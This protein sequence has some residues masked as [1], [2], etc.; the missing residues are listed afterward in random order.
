MFSAAEPQSSGNAFSQRLTKPRTKHN[1]SCL[2][3]AETS[4][5]NTT[6]INTTYDYAEDARV[7][8]SNDSPLSITGSASFR[9]SES[10]SRSATNS[11]HEAVRSR[12]ASNITMNTSKRHTI[13]ADNSDVDVAAAIALLQELK[14]RA[15]PED[16]IL[17][18]KAL[19]PTKNVERTIA[20]S[21][22]ETKDYEEPISPL[23]RRSSL[24]P[25]GVKTRL[26]REL[27]RN[28]SENN[29]TVRSASVSRQHAVVESPR[30]DVPLDFEALDLAEGS[31]ETQG[32]RPTTPSDFY[33]Q[34][35]TY[36]MGSLRITNGAASPEPARLLKRV[37]QAGIQQK[38]LVSE[39]LS[40]EGFIT[41]DEGEHKSEF[42]RPSRATVVSLRAPRRSSEE[43]DRK[44]S[45]DPRSKSK[46]RGPPVR[47]NVVAE[48]NSSA[49]QTGHP[50]NSQRA[51]EYAQEYVSEFD[52]LDNPHVDNPALTTTVSRLSTVQDES[53]V[54]GGIDAREEALRQLTGDP[55]PANDR[56][57]KPQTQKHLHVAR[58]PMTKSDSG[59]SSEASRRSI[60]RDNNCDDVL[61]AALDAADHAERNRSKESLGACAMRPSLEQINEDKISSPRSPY[62]QQQVSALQKAE[63]HRSLPSFFFKKSSSSTSVNTIATTP[64]TP[65]KQTR[66]LQKSRP[67][68]QVIAPEQVQEPEPALPEVE[69]E[70]V[71]GAPE[72]LSVNF[73]R[74]TRKLEC[75]SSPSAQSQEED[76]RDARGRGRS[77]R[78]GVTTQSAVAESPL[79]ETTRKRSRSFF[80]F[81]SRS[82]SKSQH[83]REEDVT[84]LSVADEPLPT[85]DFSDFGIVA[86]S[87]GQSPY[88]IATRGVKQ[89]GAYDPSKPWFHP[90]EI[91]RAAP[92]PDYGSEM[93]QSRGKSGD[94]SR[95]DRARSQS[96]PGE[97]IDAI[98]SSSRP[99]TRG[100]SR[101]S[102]SAH[103]ITVPRVPEAVPELPKQTERMSGTFSR[104]ASKDDTVRVGTIDFG[105]GFAQ[106]RLEPILTNSEKAKTRR[107][108]QSVAPRVRPRSAVIPEEAMPQLETQ[109]RSEKLSRDA[110]QA[111]VHEPPQAPTEKRS[112][113][114]PLELP[115][116]PSRALPKVPKHRKQPTDA[117]PALSVSTL[118]EP[119]SVPRTPASPLT[120]TSGSS[121]ESQALAWRERKQSLNEM[122]SSPTTER[123]SLVSSTPA[124]PAIQAYSPTLQ[125]P[126]RAPTVVVSRYI[127]PQGSEFAMHLD[128]EGPYRKLHSERKHR[129][130]DP[131]RKLHSDNPTDLRPAQEDVE[132]TDSSSTYRT[133]N[134]ERSQ[135]SFASKDSAKY[136]TYRPVENATPEKTSATTTPKSNS[137]QKRSSRVAEQLPP[138]PQRR[139]TAP[140]ESHD[141]PFDRFS[142]GLGY[143][144]ERGVGFGGS[145]GTRQKNDTK[146]ARKSV[147]ISQNFGVDLSDV[148]VFMVR[149]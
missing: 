89:M 54:E 7:S 26:S 107:R 97:S 93:Q 106:G 135:D 115:E 110:H 98:V 56:T 73:S 82:R 21:K 29:V 14:K 2:G 125:A 52:T 145:A 129:S 9:N 4:S 117:H 70:F 47:H 10:P 92:K 95:Q 36:K 149:N 16:L 94:R 55:L 132:R 112:Q 116:I 96:R 5:T 28:Y 72:D 141:V 49:R 78:K 27:L 126:R 137:T 68:S 104:P 58:P 75:G 123:K 24:L 67:Q 61:L 43:Q 130:E 37:E 44:F 41:A 122:L 91:S 146:A 142:G 59:Y 63:R 25:A 60:I 53:P 15:S 46:S 127:T 100:K 140:P 84:V 77:R 65:A 105:T 80:R 86:Q 31:I 143:G 38:P 102:Q 42:V 99:P 11:P 148:P 83:R 119:M 48:A 17:L 109:Q 139:A 1:S 66:K 57:R 114:T 79:E 88:D 136:R 19:L 120:P 121:W 134:S 147:V 124:S 30:L 45:S 34:I 101:R 90:H 6:P 108:T 32:G 111:P 51:S 85:H 40:G 74:P 71:S 103:N 62:V 128:E 20:P 118:K 64:V 8:F 33:P 133:A 3:K 13:A 69:P 18:H 144:W 138:R 39:S 22:P 76:E 50:Q 113:P 23:I 81:R 12:K 131:Y 87:L 35:G